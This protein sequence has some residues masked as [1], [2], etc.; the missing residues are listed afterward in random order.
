MGPHCVVGPSKFWT[1]VAQLH[2]AATPS[3]A[4]VA[5]PADDA[6][7]AASLERPMAA[8]EETL[9]GLSP[10]SEGELQSADADDA[11]RY[12][13]GAGHTRKQ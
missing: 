3:R 1:A 6:W 5:M 13:A 8:A 12:A 11:C 2:K 10:A 4:A 7:E 9:A